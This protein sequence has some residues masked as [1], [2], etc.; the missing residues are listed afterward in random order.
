MYEESCVGAPAC[1][2]AVRPKQVVGCG[3]PPFGLRPHYVMLA[4]FTGLLAFD[5][6]GAAA[7][8]GGGGIDGIENNMYDFNSVTTESPVMCVGQLC[9]YP[10]FDSPSPVVQD[11]LMQAAGVRFYF[12]HDN[13]FNGRFTSC[14]PCSV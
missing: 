14:L 8:L 11:R 12:G 13:I 5:I 7:G 6:A 10:D 4:C 9:L 3:A 1:A 2:S